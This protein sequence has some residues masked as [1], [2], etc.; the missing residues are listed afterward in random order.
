MQQSRIRNEKKNL[1]KIMK[2]GTERE[3]RFLPGLSR[4]VESRG[5]T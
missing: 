1:E 4:I 2:S 3:P 5:T